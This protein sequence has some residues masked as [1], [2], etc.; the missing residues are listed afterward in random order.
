MLTSQFVYRVEQDGQGTVDWRLVFPNLNV[1][2]VVTI[3]HDEGYTV[4][5]SNTGISP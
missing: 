3:N 4:V 1:N 2:I 5:A